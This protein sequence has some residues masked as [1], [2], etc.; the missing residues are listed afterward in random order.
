M[1]TIMGKEISL[2]EHEGQRFAVVRNGTVNHKTD[3]RDTL[4]ELVEDVM[5]VL[6]DLRTME[7]ERA[8]Q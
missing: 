2:H 8:H 6:Y 7:L 3:P 4:D 5:R 1:L